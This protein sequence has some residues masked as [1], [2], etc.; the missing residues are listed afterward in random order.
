MLAAWSKSTLVEHDVIVKPACLGSNA[1]A[2]E[3]T[4]MLG[5]NMMS[6]TMS[7]GPTAALADQMDH[8]SVKVFAN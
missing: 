1:C 5:E 4:T 7:T 3:K 8:R 6:I 2:G